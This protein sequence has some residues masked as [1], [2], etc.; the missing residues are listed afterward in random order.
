MA[1]DN[2]QLSP[3]RIESRMAKKASVSLQQGG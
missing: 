2:E 1:S 3:R